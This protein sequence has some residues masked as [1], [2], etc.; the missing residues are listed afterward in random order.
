MLLNLL[1]ILVSVK[2]VI[3]PPCAV[4]KLFQTELKSKNEAS[5]SSDVSTLSKNPEWPITDPYE[6]CITIIKIFP[7]AH[8]SSLLLFFSNIHLIFAVVCDNIKDKRL[9]YCPWCALSL[10]PPLDTEADVWTRDPSVIGAASR[11]MLSPMRESTHSHS[12]LPPTQTREKVQERD[13]V[14][15]HWREILSHRGGQNIWLFEIFDSEK[16]SILS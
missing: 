9:L 16:Q 8:F 13:K 4:E 1:G 5:L 14:C 10:S 15:V 12:N 11:P 3:S 7:R 2:N 6:I